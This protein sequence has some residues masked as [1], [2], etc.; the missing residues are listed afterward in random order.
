ME[1][2]LEILTTVSWVLL[3]PV[4][5]LLVIVL[6]KLAFILHGVSEF[7]AVARYELYPTLK[8]LRQ[9]ASRAEILSEKAVTGVETL[10][11]GVE[12]AGQGVQKIKG[13]SE[14]FA[15]GFGGVAGTFL[16]AMWETAWARKDKR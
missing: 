1:S 13:F 3:M 9:V 14:G 15:G 11:K 5:V 16:K 7:W 8:D 10:E 6:F 4:G 2:Q 12:A